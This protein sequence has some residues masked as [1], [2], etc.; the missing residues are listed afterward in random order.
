MMDHHLETGANRWIVSIAVICGAMIAGPRLPIWAAQ[1][2]RIDNGGFEE[3]MKGWLPD[4]KHE[5]VSDPSAAHTGACCLT[6]EVTGPRQALTL[7]KKIAVKAGNRYEFRVWAKAT[8]KTK[9]VLWLVSPGDPNRKIVAAWENVPARWTEYRVPLSFARDGTAELQIIAPSSHSAP[10]GRIWIDDIQLIETEMPPLLRLSEEGV[11]NDEPSFGVTRSGAVIAAWNAFYKNADHLAI[12]RLEP[13]G[14]GYRV[15]QRWEVLG[16]EGEYLLAPKA[17]SAGDS[18]AVLAAVEKNR[19]WDIQVVWPLAD[20]TTSCLPIT[21]DSAVDTDPVGAARDGKLFV[22]WETNRGGHRGIAFASLEGENVSEPTVISQQGVSAYDPTIAIA[23]DGTV[24]VAWHAFVQNN[25]DIYWRRM[26]NGK[27][28]AVERLTTAPTIDRHAV[29]AASNGAWW[30]AYENAQVKEYHVGATNQRR[31][32]LARIGDDGLETP[33]DFT[34][35]PLWQ[36]CEGASLA[37]DGQGRIWVGFLRPRLP[38]AGWEVW[39]TCFH[40]S[41]WMK[42]VPVADGKGLDRPPTVAAVDGRILVGFQMDDLPNSWSDVDLTAKAESHVYLADTK[43]AGVPPVTAMR[44]ARWEEPDEEFVPAELRL[45]HGE[46]RPTPTIEY[47]GQ[48][49]KLFFGDLH[50]HTDVSVCNRLGDQTID[51]S[52]QHMRDIAR[53]DFACATDHGYNLSPYMWNYTAKL[54]RTNADPDRF[55]TFLA[56]EW[57]STFEEYS[58]EHPYGFYGHRNLILADPYFPRWWNARNRQTPAEVWEDLRKLNA[59]FVHIPH[60]LA[61]TG[62]VPTDWNFTDE[63][64]QPVAEI[65]QTRGSYEYKGTPREAVRT[66]PPGYFLQDAWARGIVIGVIASPDHGGGYGKACVYA[67][68]LTREA[69]LEAIR[70]RHCYGTTAAKI[71][72]DVRVD[73]HLMGEKVRQPAPENVSVEITVSAPADIDRIEV[74]RNNRFIF[75]QPGDGTKANLT[76]VDRD[77]LPGRSYYYVRVI[78]KNGEIAW[79]SPVWFGAE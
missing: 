43:V 61:D 15:A 34:D 59:D 38:R 56:E 32:V 17:V 42:P 72:L 37:T 74:C 67:P 68:E 10:P 28:G 31:L 58:T 14:S 55:L 69:I 73:G 54:A 71:F 26:K 5:L 39:L 60:Q 20:G 16:G 75:Q 53:H 40:G 51:E 19:Q 49:L 7:R 9:L 27:W 47:R 30:L 65:F 78:Q 62:N 50:E 45:E 76:F 1:V 46:D 22:A 8:G 6:G 33:V 25:Y 35:S 64:A 36:R 52:Y 48:T 18:V 3:G 24:A 70:Q 21:S 66:T 41:G 23:E 77:P 2:D 11:F 57:T 29:L 4:A 13:I 44:L 12:A 63:K 79:S